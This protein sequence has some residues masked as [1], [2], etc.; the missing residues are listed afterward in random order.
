M[1]IYAKDWNQS[2]YR[3]LPFQ[4]SHPSP[5]AQLPIANFCHLAHSAGCKQGAIAL[6]PRI[7]G[8]PAI[9]IL[10]SETRN[11]RNLLHIPAIP[12]LSALKIA[13]TLAAAG[14]IWHCP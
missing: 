12:S 6:S 9:A 2:L 3:G 4:P 10:D 7:H 14:T 11:P 1:R 5:I 8:N 13:A